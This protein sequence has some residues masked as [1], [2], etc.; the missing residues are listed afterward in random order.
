MS[1]FV[2]TSFLLF[3]YKG[4]MQRGLRVCALQDIN[5]AGLV[6]LFNLS[7]VL[8]FYVVP[9]MIHIQRAYQARL[10]YRII[11]TVNKSPGRPARE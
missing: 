1:S 5:G 6:F 3:I 2:E 7:R 9:F 10:T 4:G 8:F 11:Y